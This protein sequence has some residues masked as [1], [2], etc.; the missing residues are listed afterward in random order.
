MA[1][2][3][4]GNYFMKD[5]PVVATD[6]TADNRYVHFVDT[7]SSAINVSAPVGA[8]KGYT[9]AIKDHMANSSTNNIT[10]NLYGTNDVISVDD[11]LVEYTYINDTLGWQKA[12]DGGVDEE[13]LLG[14][15]EGGYEF[16]GGFTD[17]TTGQSGA[18]DVGSDVEYTSTM[19]SNNAFLRFGFDTARQTAND[20]PYWGDGA[21]AN[22]APHA[23]TT[24]YEGVG[25]FSGSYMPSGVSSMFAYG[26]DTAYNAESTSGVIYNAALGSYDMSQLNVGDYCQ[27]RFDFNITAQ[28]AH[29]TVEVGLIWQTRD[30]NDNGTYTFFLAG[31]PI[32]LG[33]TAG[34]TLLARPTI[35][36]Y[37]A[38]AEDVNAR[39][40]PAI[41]ADRPVFV[42]PLTTLYTVSR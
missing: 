22:E 10:V 12:G 23:G 15:S 30:G 39:A 27:F 3:K 21:D 9:F 18:T 8:V 25:L 2:L 13:S 24:A 38:S 28:E 4:F 7:T 17:R 32:Y 41:R 36:A 1:N 42:Q 5:D 14:K 6:F 37:L 29:T 19:V 35:S 34:D 40:L 11:A 31:E 26:E 20:T 33:A 16:T